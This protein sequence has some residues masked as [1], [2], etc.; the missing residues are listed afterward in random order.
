[1]LKQAAEETR[2]VWIVCACD[3]WYQDWSVFIFMIP[4]DCTVTLY[5]S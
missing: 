2:G 3:F 5:R 1:M 4:G